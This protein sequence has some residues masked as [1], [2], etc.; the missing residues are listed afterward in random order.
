MMMTR[1]MNSKARTDQLDI[2]TEQLYYVLN[3]PNPTRADAAAS[4]KPAFLHC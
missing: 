2:S 3:Y 4:L 1:S